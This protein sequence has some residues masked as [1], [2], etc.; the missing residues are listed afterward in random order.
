M[1]AVQDTLGALDQLVPYSTGPGA[2]DDHDRTT[3]PTDS[4][5]PQADA[6]ST[7]TGLKPIARLTSDSRVERITP[8]TDARTVLKYSSRF[9]RDFIRSDYNFCAAKVAVARNGKLRAL[10]RAFREADE[11]YGK[12]LAWVETHNARSFPLAHEEIE[13]VV[14]HPLAGRLVRCLTRYDRIF[15]RS[16]ETVLSQKI[17]PADRAN[18]L[19]NAERRI[20]QIVQ[21]CIPDNDEYDFDGERREK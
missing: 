14:T 3:A 5:A 19:A 9:A 7:G 17:Q 6:Q 20:R 11:W 2:F 12:A 1:D 21:V 15:T 10:D 8:T 13:L 18:L 16:M 4:Q